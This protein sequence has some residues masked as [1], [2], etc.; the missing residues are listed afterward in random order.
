[1]NRVF[2][3]LKVSDNVLQIKSN[4]LEECGTHWVL[5]PGQG[6]SFVTVG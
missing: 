3:D 4:D 2:L 5:H 1:M 6:S